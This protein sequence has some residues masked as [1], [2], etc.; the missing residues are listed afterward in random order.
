[1]SVSEEDDRLHLNFWQPTWPYQAP[2]FI[3]RRRFV[4]FTKEITT[5]C[6]SK[7]P[8]CQDR[9][10]SKDPRLRPKWYHKQWSHLFNWFHKL[11]SSSLSIHER[12]NR[13]PFEPLLLPF[14]DYGKSQDETRHSEWSRELLNYWNDN[15]VFFFFKMGTVQWFRLKPIRTRSAWTWRPGR[16]TSVSHDVLVSVWLPIGW[17]NNV[18]WVFSASLKA[19]QSKFICYDI[20]FHTLF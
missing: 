13:K 17:E 14:K 7:A 11:E 16:E 18:T 2:A 3:V 9:I 15:D 12:I 5:V 4:P 10:M 20:T 6:G 19:W 1:M 8:D